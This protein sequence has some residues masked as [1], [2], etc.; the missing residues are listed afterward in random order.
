MPLAVAPATICPFYIISVNYITDTC[1]V[2][3]KYG[4]A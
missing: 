2:D 3:E 4:Y 1:V